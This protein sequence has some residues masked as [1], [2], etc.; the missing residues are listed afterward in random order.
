MLFVFLI[1]LFSGVVSSLGISPAIREYN[2]VPGEVIEITYSVSAESENPIDVYASGAL[3]EYATLSTEVL[4]KGSGSFTVTIKLPAELDKPGLHSMAVGA[5]ERPPEDAF[6]GTV[7]GINAVVRINVPYPGRYTEVSLKIPDGNVDEEIPVE[8]KVINRG[9]EPLFVDVGVD[10]YEES[11]D[12]VE[13]MEFTS[14]DLA[15][16]EERF[17][18]KFLN[19]AKYKPGNYYAEAIVD[20]GETVKVND[21]FRIGSL[22]INVINFTEEIKRGGLQ[23]FVIGVQSFWNGNLDGVFADVNLSKNGNSIVEFRTPP[24]DLNAWETDNLVSYVNTDGFEGTYDS[25]ITLIYSGQEEEFYGKLNIIEFNYIL[26][27]GASILG[28][29]IIIGAIIYF[30]RKRN[31]NKYDKYKNESKEK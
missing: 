26:L 21:T 27:I 19:T 3:S 31:K 28:G 5:K 24:I 15:I 18:R 23:P 25:E 17:F 2:F 1:I 29:G 30:I 7:V 9:R 13:K 20:F 6:L 12:F 11:G 22:F 8:T 4:E 14:V 10:F 16:G